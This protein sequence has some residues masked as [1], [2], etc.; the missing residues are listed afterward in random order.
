VVLPAGHDASGHGRGSDSFDDDVLRTRVEV[1]PDDYDYLS[2][3]LR[4]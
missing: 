2:E 3:F 4:P 1:V